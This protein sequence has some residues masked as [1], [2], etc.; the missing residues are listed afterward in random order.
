MPVAGGGFEQCYNAQAMVDTE[1]MPVLVP[2]VVQGANDKP[3]IV[4]MLDTL[5]ALPEGLNRPERLLADAGYFSKDNVE[6][7]E[8]AGIEP[9]IAVGRDSH[10]PHGSERFSEPPE[11][12]PEATPLERMV[13]R[14]K[15]GVGRAAYA[16]RK[17]TV[18]PVFGIIKSAMGFRRF[19]T[20]G[21]DNVQGEWTLMC[22]AWNLKRMAVLRPY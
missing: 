10:H 13:N 21:L 16:L 1:F 22:L 14:L 3:Q 12:A 20:R 4:P 18:E 6:A 7:C 19:L 11:P 17:Q 9:S 8:A 15:T 2:Q 5:Q